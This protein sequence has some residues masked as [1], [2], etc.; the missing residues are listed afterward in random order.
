MSI[1]L[2]LIFIN[3]VVTSMFLQ[4]PSASSVC[5]C[6]SVL[7]FRMVFACHEINHCVA[8]KNVQVRRRTNGRSSNSH[9][10]T[11][12]EYSS[13]V[14]PETN[15]RI[16][17]RDLSFCIAKVSQLHPLTTLKGKNTTIRLMFQWM[18][19]L[20]FGRL[21]C[22]ISAGT[23]KIMTYS[24]RGFPPIFQAGADV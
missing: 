19:N 5:I 17:L 22:R 10:I 12:N 4:S 3:G 11:N 2:I 15:A 14:R 24:F 23:P 7:Q 1:L 16:R 20:A 6:G 13:C 21:S 9:L 18:S 8:W